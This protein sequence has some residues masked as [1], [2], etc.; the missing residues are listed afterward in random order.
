[1]TKCAVPW[2]TGFTDNHG[3][4]RNCCVANPQIRSQP[5][6]SFVTWWHS[7]ELQE[8]RNQL[9]DSLP[10]ACA[11][12]ELQE[13]VQGSSFRTAVNSQ[14]SV[15]ALEFPSRW[16]VMFDNTCNLACWTCDEHSSS[17]IET[18]KRK[19]G[20][21][22]LDY[23]DSSVRIDAQWDD[24]KQSILHSYNLHDT[25][26][27]TVLGGEPLFNS[28]VISFLQ[29]LVDVGLATRTRLEFHTNGTM[30]NSRLSKLLQDNWQYICIFVSL[31]AVGK[32]AEWVRYNCRW[33][34][35]DNNINELKHLANYIEVHC[36][37]SVL[38]IGGLSALSQYCKD[39]NLSLQI[40][41]L[42]NPSFMSLT[43]W[44][45][46]PDLLCNYNQ[47]Q[48]FGFGQYYNEIGK[49]AH[50]GA[51]DQLYNYIKRFDSLRA[52]LSN[53]DSRL[54]LALGLT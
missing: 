15:T 34:N 42:E 40:S 50:I 24:L 54:A 14:V 19:L 3:G 27:L 12:C 2:S 22:P 9:S 25:V 53:F 17:V 5:N 6:Q 43:N 39:K 41:M 46:D 52:N 32:L 48:Q 23:V 51:R 36:T 44:D 16:N 49:T 13:Q 35:V 47:L 29:H 21:L 18:Q 45:Q 4:Y 28:R 7:K 1:M 20:I 38:N 26:T 37:L 31:D 33:E 30:Y 11:G 10:T 8:F